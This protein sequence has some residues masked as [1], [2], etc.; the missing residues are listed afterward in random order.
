MAP[1][2]AT[3]KG[4]AKGS[5]TVEPPKSALLGDKTKSTFFFPSTVDV[6]ELRASFRPLWGA[7]TGGENSGHPATRV[8]PAAC[9][10]PAPNR[11]P[12]FVDYL[13]CGLWP[14]FS[15]FFCNIMHTFGFRLL[16]F[17]PNAVACMAF[18][19]HL[20]EGFAGVQ[21]NTALFRHYFFPR[22]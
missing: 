10:D 4:V 21:P 22:I 13:S 8:I 9:A 18:F 15:D 11:Y 19:V 3:G 2:S 20:C 17:T 7:K 12:F 6:H 5:G 1:K 16:D 14:P